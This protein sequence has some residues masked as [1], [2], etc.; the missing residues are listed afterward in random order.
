MDV[1]LAS[2][3]RMVLLTSR[4]LQQ[5]HCEVLGAAGCDPRAFVL[6]I[7]VQLFRG[8]FLGFSCIYDK[9]MMVIGLSQFDFPFL[10]AFE[11][12]Y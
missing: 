2:W 12:F 10:W 5:E 6:A 4:S 8:D 11:A 1:W 3:C 9:L 7:L